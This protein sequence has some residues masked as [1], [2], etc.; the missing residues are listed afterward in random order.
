MSQLSIKDIKKGGHVT[1]IAT[2]SKALSYLSGTM[3]FYNIPLIDGILNGEYTSSS[4]ANDTEKEALASLNINTEVEVSE[5]RINIH[6]TTYKIVKV[7]EKDKQPTCFLVLNAI[8]S[9]WVGSVERA[10]LLNGSPKEDV[11]YVIKHTEFSSLKLLQ[12]FLRSTFQRETKANQKVFDGKTFGY[13]T[14]QFFW[15]IRPMV[16][17]KNFEDIEEN[18]PYVF[19]CI[20]QKILNGLNELHNEKH[21]AHGDLKAEH[22]YIQKESKNAQFID[23]GNAVENGGSR[24][25]TKRAAMLLTPL[26]FLGADALKDRLQSSTTK[27]S[28]YVD[29]ICKLG[30]ILF[31]KIQN[32]KNLKDNKFLLELCQTMLKKEKN[33]ADIKSDFDILMGVPQTQEHQLGANKLQIQQQSS[34]S[35]S[36]IP[37]RLHVHYSVIPRKPMSRGDRQIELIKKQIIELE[38]LILKM[39][40]TLEAYDFLRCIIRSGKELGDASINTLPALCH[41]S[42]AVLLAADFYFMNTVL[43]PQIEKLHLALYLITLANTYYADKNVT[44]HV[45][46]NQPLQNLQRQMN[47][48]YLPTPKAEMRH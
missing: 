27:E 40:K 48:V 44:E 34:S 1:R 33:I 41:L 23:F 35:S 30:Q 10:I 4:Q 3:G 14:H 29:D 15:V 32:N 6:S 26:I 16:K 11:E 13:V 19:M 28:T 20:V 22:I 8:G 21:L 31:E 47:S 17:G 25:M 43:R 42:P 9:G 45:V 12:D 7:T 2:S 36:S 39:Q 38:Y 24:G 37:A 5:T 46:C 18:D